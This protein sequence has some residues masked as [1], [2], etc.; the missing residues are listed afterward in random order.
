LCFIMTGLWKELDLLNSADV[1]T[2]WSPSNVIDRILV[3]GK[4]LLLTQ[5]Y[6]LINKKKLHIPGDS[7]FTFL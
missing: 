7:H 2:P 5:V 4:D 3:A 1:L 6:L